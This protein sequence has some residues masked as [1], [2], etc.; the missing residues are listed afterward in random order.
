MNSLNTQEGISGIINFNK[1]RLSTQFKE[2]AKEGQLKF[3]D[4]FHVLRKQVDVGNRQFLVDSTTNKIDG[5]SDFD[6]NK[7]EA[8]K[9]LI[10]DRI[11]IGYDKDPSE[12]K[13]GVLGYQKALPAAFR[14]AKLVIDQDGKLGEYPLSELVNK[15]TGNSVQDDYLVLKHPIVLVG[16]PEFVFELVFPKGVSD[17]GTDKH[18]LELTASGIVVQRSTAA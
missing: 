13:E 5:V 6:K 4:S 1:S 18:Y 15:Y 3:M 12:G 7:F 9:V 8:G 16:G 11:K 10:V 2:S 17:T 14:N